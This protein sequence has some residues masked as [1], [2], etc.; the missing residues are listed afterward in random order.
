MREDYP[1]SNNEEA[2]DKP[3]M[4]YIIFKKGFTLALSFLEVVFRVPAA[5]M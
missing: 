5:V 1:E 4:E 3:Q 2:P